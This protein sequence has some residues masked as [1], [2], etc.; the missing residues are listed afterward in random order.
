MRARVNLNFITVVNLNINK[1]SA[2]FDHILVSDHKKI[3]NEGY[4]KYINP[5]NYNNYLGF[6]YSDLQPRDLESKGDPINHLFCD[7]NIARRNFP[8]N[9]EKP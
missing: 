3:I 2:Y 9:V 8:T 4:E 7:K 5:S 1:Y 6:P